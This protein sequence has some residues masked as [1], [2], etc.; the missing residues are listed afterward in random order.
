MHMAKK[1]VKAQAGGRTFAD[2]LRDAPY[3]FRYGVN[4][5]DKVR[6]AD[7]GI[8]L[9]ILSEEAAEIPELADRSA[10]A[11][12]GT[13]K[14]GAFPALTLHHIRQILGG[15]SGAKQ[16]FTNAAIR[17]AS[18]KIME[19]NLKGK[20]KPKFAKGGKVRKVM[21]EFKS[22]EL[23][24]GSKRGPKVK[25]RKQ[26]IAIAM[27]EARKAGE[28]VPR[29]RAQGGGL[30]SK[31]STA[32]AQRFNLP[33]SPG[34]PLSTKPGATPLVPLQQQRI[35]DI[36]ANT[37]GITNLAG[38]LQN[39]QPGGGQDVTSLRNF[40]PLTGL[41]AQTQN[42]LLTSGFQTDVAPLTEAAKI[43]AGQEFDTATSG[44]NERLASIGLLSSSAQTAAEARERAKMGERIGATGLE[45]GVSAAE[46]AAGRRVGGIGNELAVSGQRLGA[47]QGAL[48]G[49][50]EQ[51]GQRLSGLGTALGGQ[52]SAAGL[53]LGAAEGRAGAGQSLIN[54]Q[55]PQF[56]TEMGQA[57]ASV[58]APRRSTT[59]T[60]LGFGARGGRADLGDY[61][62]N[63]LYSK[64]F[65]RRGI[66]EQM[67]SSRAGAGR[68]SRDPF[69]G[70]RKEIL[71]TQL[72]QMKNPSRGGRK[73]D[74][75]L[76]KWKI[77]NTASGRG[78]D[79]DRMRRELALQ[80]IGAG[81]QGGGA[82][83]FA[84]TDPRDLL[85]SLPGGTP[86]SSGG[87][88]F[89]Q[90]TAGG[91]FAGGGDTYATALAQ[92]QFGA[93]GG[94]PQP[95]LPQEMRIQDPGVMDPRRRFYNLGGPTEVFDRRR[96]DEG[97]GMAPGED[98]G[99]DKIPAMLRSEELVLTP[100]LAMA[101][102]AANPLE[103][104]PELI[105]SLQDLAKQPLEFDEDSGEHMAAEGGTS[106][107]AGGGIRPGSVADKIATLL[108]ALSPGGDMSGG[109]QAKAGIPGAIA[110][111]SFEE[112]FVVPTPPSGA[113]PGPGPALALPSRE[114]LLRQ[115]AAA[116][117]AESLG[118][119][120]PAEA[121]AD[122]GS[123]EL[124][125]LGPGPGSVSLERI[126]GGQLT[127]AGDA[128]FGRI[129]PQPGRKGSFSAMTTTVPS[130]QPLSPEQQVQQRLNDATRRRDLIGA[131]LNTDIV[132]S[133]EKQARLLTALDNADR[134]VSTITNEVLAR[135][136]QR[137]QREETGVR[138]VMAQANLNESIASTLRSKAQQ[139]T[140]EAALAKQMLE[141][142]TNDPVVGQILNSLEKL[143]G[144]KDPRT[145]AMYEAVFGKL[146]ESRG[147]QIRE[148]GWLPKLF[149]APEFEVEPVQQEA[150]AAPVAPGDD[151]TSML[152]ASRQPITPEML[153]YLSQY[154]TSFAGVQ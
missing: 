47:T 37:S 1:R 18:T 154:D 27:S 96:F 111:P 23:R 139:Q 137:M 77:A 29:R 75:A 115:G 63:L 62:S 153:A 150:G 149:G 82:V 10:A 28:D 134:Q 105:M 78:P 87:R 35:N 15:D 125:S 100:E 21:H 68:E 151:I 126:G 148:N 101:V 106:P 54:S 141:A 117:L 48:Q 7:S 146:L 19:Q 30:M 122:L 32:G 26:A 130:A 143:G 22:G 72:M 52:T 46:A 131:A 34:K 6:L 84:D 71:R 91:R 66:P 11:Y 56:S 49:S 120:S 61:L 129:T 83:G 4:A 44:I 24:S 55:L 65:T 138:R 121:G 114:D 112:E 16:A 102:E 40:Q 53:N 116:T 76:E 80:F 135:E 38:E 9:G 86:S 25:S 99:E 93:G 95:K 103:P 60:T 108:A 144:I 119:P 127:Q 124:G 73:F 20:A 69:E 67:T 140:A 64:E 89:K 45:A 79:F 14:W 92:R 147:I 74:P 31:L 123:E 58:R 104:N 57:P 142:S 8:P 50:L 107:F 33:G 36:K 3:Q 118:I 98:T 90:S 94:V 145:A 97:G 2:D 133:P 81:G 109:F 113:V 5:E 12:L 51:S 70:L 110:P 43:R 132:G 13:G 128:G 88:G 85:K 59:G 136:Q 152:A 17:G 42:E 41:G 39:F